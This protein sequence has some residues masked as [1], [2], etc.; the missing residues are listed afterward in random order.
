MVSIQVLPPP[1]KAQTPLS[2]ILRRWNGT[3]CAVGELLKR[4]KIQI[5]KKKRLNQNTMNKDVRIKG[6]YCGKNGRPK[7]SLLTPAPG[8]N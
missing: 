3:R 6:G 2:Q 5:K 7:K 8:R 1:S 4:Q